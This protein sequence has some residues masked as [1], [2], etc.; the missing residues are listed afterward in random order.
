MIRR[1]KLAIKSL[2]YRLIKACLV[3]RK[4]PR[5][6][7]V[8]LLCLTERGRSLPYLITCLSR[9]VAA[10]SIHPASYPAIWWDLWKISSRNRAK[11]VDYRTR[12]SEWTVLS[13]K[14]LEGESCKLLDYDYYVADKASYFLPFYLHP[15]V[16]LSNLLHLLPTLR[17]AEKTVGVF[18]AGSVSEAY[19]SVHKFGFE[20]R[21]EITDSLVSNISP[22]KLLVPSSRAQLF[23]ALEQTD[24][25]RV[26]VL[27]ITSNRANTLRKHTLR[28]LEYFQIMARSW[29][30]YCPPGLHPLSHNIVEAMAMGAIPVF[31]YGA[32]FFPRLKHMESC[33]E[34][35]GSDDVA[36]AIELALSLPIET[37]RRMSETVLEIYQKEIDLSSDFIHR[38][39][40]IRVC[41]EVPTTRLFMQRVGESDQNHEGGNV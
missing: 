37:R 6:G 40:R 3:Q 7:G 19:E 4:P 31:N 17:S 23:N 20:S 10:L 5:N 8:V 33:I 30:A 41:D 22:A 32:V 14:H 27:N 25:R 24:L 2:I 35:R 39:D 34:Y 28:Q 15:D 26:C 1:L 36:Q 38:S 29:F 21:Q 11:L 18:F 13:S 12:T 9:G 16:Y